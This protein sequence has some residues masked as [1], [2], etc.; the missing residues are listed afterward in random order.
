MLLKKHYYL[1]TFLVIY[2]IMAIYLLRFY[3]YQINP[4][5]ISLINIAKEIKNGHLIEA[6]NAYWGILF[7]LLLSPFLFLPLSPLYA[8]KVMSIIIG[9][10]TIIGVYNLSLKINLR[11]LFLSFLLICLIPLVIYFS[12]S[13]TT[14]D[15]LQLTIFIFYLSVISSQNYSRKISS[16]FMVG[17]IGALGFLA[18]ENG[19]FF[20][21][22]HFSLINI[23]YFLYFKG[24]ENRIKL[25]KTF[26][27]GILTFL[28]ISSI[29]IFMLGLKYHQFMIGS[30]GSY[31]WALVGPRTSGH[32]R[33]YMGFLM[34]PTRHS[35]SAWDDPTY[36]SP[37]SWSIFESIETFRF[38]LAK[39][40][41]NI[42][43]S[44]STFKSFSFVFIPLSFLLFVYT[45]L[46]IF[47]LRKQ[48]LS[49]IG[50]ISIF[51]AFVIHASPYIMTY[52]DERYLW[53][54]FILLSLFGFILLEKFFSITYFKRFPHY[55]RNS[56]AFIIGLAF[57]LTISY[58][59]INYLKT[60]L[61][62]DRFFFE[63]GRLLLTKYGIMNANLAS[64]DNW[65]W[66]L[67]YTFYTNGRYLGIS[68]QNIDFLKL[69]E[70]IKK[71]NIDYYFVWNN[72]QLADTLSTV[73]PE[74][75]EE[76]SGYRI[77]FIKN[78]K[79]YY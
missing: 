49:N 37:P 10:F 5:G 22:M 11:P 8:Q 78:N 20:F 23:F 16:G 38:Q 45:F 41:T 21:L 77:F 35:I 50:I 17:L 53:M 4:D 66:M 7:S 69:L 59:S 63:Q 74:L 58:K 14:T 42:Q 19:F 34:P 12:L 25:T 31:N 72:D 24:R 1:V 33:F 39:V 62:V 54:N 55:F 44:L 43:I 47:L 48:L 32:P 51:I 75:P 70:D 60:T 2:L 67:T 65:N 9:V 26:A 57:A 40:W 36:P 30:R 13:V 6:I 29:W 18:K 61:N 56:F 76:I 79:S 46:Y 27:V 68:R 28:F 3:A 15:L 52:L 73:F 64:N 71:Y